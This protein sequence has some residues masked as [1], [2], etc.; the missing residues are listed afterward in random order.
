MAKRNS[1]NLEIYGLREDPDRWEALIQ[2]EIAASQTSAEARQIVDSMYWEADRSA[3]FQ[4]F[5]DSLDFQ[6]INDLL[7]IVGARPEWPI[8]EIG[9]GS[10]Q[11]S[12]SL[13]ESGFENVELL[14]PN[15][16]WITGTGY[17]ETVLDAAQGRLRICNSLDSWYSSPQQFRMVI[18]RNCVHH[19]PNIAMTAA[20]IRQKLSKGGI[21]VMIREWYAENTRELYQRLAKHPYCQ[22]YQVYEFPY[23]PWHYSDCIEYAGF[24]L[25]RVVPEGYLNNA[26]S[27]YISDPGSSWRQ[28]RSSYQ[29]RI[30]KKYPKLGVALYRLQTN[31]SRSLRYRVGSYRCPQVMVFR[32]EKD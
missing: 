2:E 15:S 3:A 24:S 32:K 14:E 23:P 26:L 28:F 17:L 27:T 22:K 6:G 9:G 5:R 16:R 19:F 30:F 12:W 4:R 7:S 8:C 25:Q 31:T 10:G 21:W 11:L 18:T 1:S 20:C 29:R 13:A